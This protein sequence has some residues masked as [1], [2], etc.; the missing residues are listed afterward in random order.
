MERI[1]LLLL[2]TIM[3]STTLSSEAQF[4]KKLKNKVQNSVEQVVT[5]RV[6]NEAANQAG[7][8]LDSIMTFGG[9]SYKTFPVG[10]ES[11]SMDDVPDAYHFEWVYAIR[12]NTN[13]AQGELDIDYYLKKKAPYWGAKI[14]Q[15]MELMMVYDQS[16]SLTVMFME[17]E[18]NKI[19][20]VTKIPDTPAMIAE[21]ND[22]NADLSNYTIREI[23]GKNIL[24]YSCKGFEIENHKY[25]FII[26]NTFETEVSFSDVYGKS[27]Q[28]PQGFDPN[29][30]KDGE[31][32]G[33]IMEMTVIDKENESGNMKM[34]CTWLEPISLY[35]KKSDYTTF[36]QAGKQ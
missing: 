30:L 5:D 34:E 1:K 29:W 21:E 25:R 26:Y 14:N 6:A 32:E 3:F 15:G 9:K 19:A 36:S 10:T 16:R 33:L 12:I 31:N 2:I 17:T 24:G 11:A 18:G 4:L 13:R 22:E 35:L 23:P 20:S 27:D 8:V 7:N 28:F